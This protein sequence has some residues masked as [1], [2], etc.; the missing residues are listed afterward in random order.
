M[1][2]K[3][4]VLGRVRELAAA[5]DG[6][7]EGPG[8]AALQAEVGELHENVEAALNTDAKSRLMRPLGFW[9]PDNGTSNCCNTKMR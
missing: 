2:G 8:R 9:G 5:V 3:D 1:T 7:P 6:L 4:E